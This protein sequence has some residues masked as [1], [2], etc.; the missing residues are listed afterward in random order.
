MFHLLGPCP[1]IHP[2]ADLSEHSED[3]QKPIEKETFCPGQLSKLPLC[4]SMTCF[5]QMENLAFETE[6]LHQ[7]WSE[8]VFENDLFFHSTDS[9][10]GTDG[11]SE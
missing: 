8:G 2:S 9:Y 4:I 11:F 6:A 10:Y 5:G 7:F 1:A 3:S